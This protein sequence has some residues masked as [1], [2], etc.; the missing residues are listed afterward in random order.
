MEPGTEVGE[1]RQLLN[2]IRALEHFKPLKPKQRRY[3]IAYAGCGRITGASA[4]TG[5]PWI[6]HYH[7]LERDELYKQAFNKARE[8]FSD[9][10][11]GEV[12]QRAFF[13]EEHRIFK[14]GVAVESYMQKSDIL[15]MFALK[16]LKPQYRDN[17]IN[18]SS[19]G[20]IQVNV[21]LG[22][23]A[24]DITKPVAIETQDVAF[25]PDKQL[26]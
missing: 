3:I 15:A 21:S 20:P 9:F 2:Q 4:I 18:Q 6:T 23:P 10:A 13:G 8:M 25:D 12:F 5:V 16:G 7:W 19:I 14:K 17:F 11:E 22:A 1:S 24:L 26:P